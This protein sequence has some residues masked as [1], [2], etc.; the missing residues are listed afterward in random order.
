[1]KDIRKFEDNDLVTF[2]DILHTS[3]EEQETIEDNLAIIAFVRANNMEHFA[4]YVRNLEQTIDRLEGE[5]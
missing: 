1:M 3:N 5:K 2:L 4:A